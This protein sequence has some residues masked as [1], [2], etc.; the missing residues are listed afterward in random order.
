MNA[1][2]SSVGKR[3]GT[4]VMQMKK[5]PVMFLSMV[6]AAATL[7]GCAGDR[8]TQKEEATQQWNG[9]RAAVLHGLAIDQ[10][11]NGNFDKARETVAQ[12]MRLDPK[13]AKLHQLSAKVA[14]EQGQ[15]E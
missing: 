4:L 9:A 8:K 11:Q 7:V 15:L 5:L 3:E 12:A 14:I 10:F 13:N 2:S 6:C 1:T